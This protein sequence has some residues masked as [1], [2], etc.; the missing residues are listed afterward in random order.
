MTTAI[1]SSSDA[2]STRRRWRILLLAIVVGG[3]AVAGGGWYI[4]Y[5]LSAPAPP[6]IAFGDGAEPAVVKVVEAAREEVRRQPRSGAAWGELGKVLLANGYSDEAEGC[7]VRAE[8]F[9]PGEPRWPY[10]RASRMLLRDREAAL[11]HLRRAVDLCEEKD[12]ENTTPRLLLSE[13]YLE[14]NDWD[15]V[16]A[17][18]RHVLQRQPDNPRAHH[19]LG[20]VALAR[21]DLAASVAHLLRAAESPLTRQRACAQLAAVYQRLGDLAAAEERSRLAGRL[22]PDQP[23]PD[24]YV[25]EYRRLAAGRQ[26]RFLEAEHLGHEAERLEAE[27]RLREAQGR[28]RE[29]ARVLWEIADDFPDGRSY[30]ALGT[31]LAKLEDYPGAEQALRAALRAE[32]DKI[33]AHYALAV[34]LFRQGEQLRERDSDFAA[35]KY[36]AAVEAARRVI[37]LKP[38]HAMAH[39]FL[40]RALDRLGRRGEALDALRTA[41]RCRPEVAEIHLALGETLAAGGQAEEANGELRQAEQLAPNDPRIQEGIKRVR[42]ANNKPG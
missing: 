28:L 8:Q 18:C 42:G 12:P 41:T 20:M 6:Q 9:D 1:G 21:G 29:V 10:L 11:P 19:T 3:A 34:V 33:A 31:V 17:Q 23:W 39:Y 38:D 5:R 14:K 32:P 25:L 16:E 13:V 36:R 26:E 40:G 30:V 4:W 35:E 24:P 37:G 27:G 22:P 7:F 2:R 15:E